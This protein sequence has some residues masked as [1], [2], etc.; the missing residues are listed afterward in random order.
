MQV[1]LKAS[2][3]ASHDLYMKE[4]LLADLPVLQMGSTVSVIVV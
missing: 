2:E 4:S 3:A 1:Q